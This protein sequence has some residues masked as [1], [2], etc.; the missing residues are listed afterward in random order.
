MPHDLSAAEGAGTVE[1]KIAFFLRSEGKPVRY[2]YDNPDY[3]PNFDLATRKVPV[4]DARTRRIPPSW[5]LEGFC[6][7]HAPTD[8]TEFAD[9]DAVKK[10]YLPQ[11]KAM[12]VRELGAEKVVVFN[13]VLLSSRSGLKSSPGADIPAFTAHNDYTPAVAPARLRQL[14]G[15]AE[16]DRWLKRRAIQV[17]V[18]RPFNS[19]VE[20]YPLA[21]CDGRTVAPRH[22]VA[23]DLRFVDRVS[24]FQFLKHS[25]KQRWWYFPRMSTDEV[26][27]LKGWD[28]GSS[29][30]AALAPHAAL[31][32]AEV[33]APRPRET[34]VARAFV[35]LPP[36]ESGSGNG[37]C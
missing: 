9:P 3:V 25:A 29:S 36:A 31:Q 27:I 12:L 26:L 21:I 1:A 2:A 23:A 32:R 7:R 24:E 13:Y 33:P 10:R 18:W 37:R 8:F 15:D 30:G 35:L 11:V 4:G 20:E 14:V 6:L 28:S 19:P 16:A 22:L 34:I 17:N 5:N